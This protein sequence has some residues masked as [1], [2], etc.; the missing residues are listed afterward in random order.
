MEH[1]LQDAL[2][3]F[4]ERVQRA[5]TPSLSPIIVKCQRYIIQ[6]VYDGL[7]LERIAHYIKLSSSYVS[8]LFKSETGIAINEAIQRAR[9][10]EAE[11]L[12]LLSSHPIAVISA[13]LHFTDQS[14]F[15]KV[16]KKHTGLTPKQYR[17]SIRTK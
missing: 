6:H 8:I 16:F 5:K 11:S 13:C 3:A 17:Q 10:E 1:L 2:C 7:S 12:L 9:I 4:T 14:H 15:T